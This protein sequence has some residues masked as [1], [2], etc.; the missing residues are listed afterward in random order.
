M[1]KKIYCGIGNT[2]KGYRLGS[3][4]EC[5]EN[6]KVNLY[7]LYKIDSKLIKE[8]LAEKKKE[9]K[10]DKPVKEMDIRLTQAALKGKI[11]AFNREVKTLEKEDDD[12]NLPLIKKIT[13]QIEKTNEEIKKLSELI[14]KIKDGNVVKINLK[15]LK[16]VE[17]KIPTVDEIKGIKKAK[18][19]TKKT[20]KK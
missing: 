2:P 20:S 6:K 12:R 11:T 5:L 19:P 18:K 10:K 4:V 3:M 15:D 13:K 1:S 9:S 16:A 7:G 8:K 14:K 17:K